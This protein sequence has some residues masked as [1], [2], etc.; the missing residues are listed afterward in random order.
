QPVGGLL[1]AVFCLTLNLLL[2]L[3]PEYH[4]MDMN[5]ITLI[6]ISLLMD[7]QYI[8]VLVVT[9]FDVVLYTTAIV[10]T[11]H[12]ARDVVGYLL[13]VYGAA[14]VGTYACHRREREFRYSYLHKRILKDNKFKSE[15]LLK[16]MFPNVKHISALVRNKRV[17]DHLEDVTIMFSDLKGYTEWAS[18]ESPR[19]V[20]R[21]LNKVVY[22]AFD[23]HLD[24]LGVYKL[25]TVGDAFVVVAGLEGFKSKDDHAMAMVKYAFRMLFEL[26]RIKHEE[27]L[28]FEMRIGLHTGPCIGGVIGRLKPRY[29]CWG[30]TP[31][32]SNMLEAAGTPGSL[33]V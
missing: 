1:A 2:Y 12:K 31:L 28:N 26:E 23:S 16:N 8:Y 14:L 21:V 9:I 4:M 32:I 19:E 27:D 5:I 25:D 17:V 30:R 11:N 7:L 29:L 18:T 20:Y 33:L 24:G 22:T 13:F 10:V 6:T 3:V 15:E